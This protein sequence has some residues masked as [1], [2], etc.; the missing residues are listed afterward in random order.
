M[1]EFSVDTTEV[2]RLTANTRAVGQGLRS[3]STTVES[4]TDAASATGSG[5]A[6]AAF[7]SFCWQWAEELRQEGIAWEQ[8]TTSML[9][10]SVLYE[11]AEAANDIFNEH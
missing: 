4:L 8:T 5:A 9:T 2:R 1:N 10:A 7:T 11:A 6:A 3:L